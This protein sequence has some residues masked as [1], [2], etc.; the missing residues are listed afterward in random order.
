MQ[1]EQNILR[2]RQNKNIT[3]VEVHMSKYKE[4]I[5]GLKGEIDILR[6]QLRVEQEKKNANDKVRNKQIYNNQ[7]LNVKTAKP[8]IF[9]ATDSSEE[10]LNFNDFKSQIIDQ[11]N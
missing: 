11:D 6:D 1:R 2:I 8:N 10:K 5:D 7:I 4:I 3:E 9:D